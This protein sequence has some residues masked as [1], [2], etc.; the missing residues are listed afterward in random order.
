MRR[1]FA[2]TAA[3]AMASLFSLMFWSQVG[4]V[5]NAVARPKP[6]FYAAKS[7]PYLPVQKLDPVY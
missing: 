5:A 7:S 4:A 2:V 3:I 1:L 6:H